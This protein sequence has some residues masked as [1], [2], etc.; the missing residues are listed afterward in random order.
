MSNNKTIRIKNNKSITANGTNTPN[1]DN[2]I[3]TISNLTT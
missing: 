2:T 1:I 3:N